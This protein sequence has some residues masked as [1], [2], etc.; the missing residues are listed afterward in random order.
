MDI[1]RILLFV[2]GVL[3]LVLI[4]IIIVSL[5]M[6][7]PEKYFNFAGPLLGFTSLILIPTA[8]WY[9]EDNDRSPALWGFLVFFAPVPMSLVLAFL[10][11]KDWGALNTNS[12]VEDTNILSEFQT[13]KEQENPYAD[14]VV[15]PSYSKS[16]KYLNELITIGSQEGFLS[17]EP[18]GNFNDDLHNKKARKIGEI[19]YKKG[20]KE[21]MQEVCSAVHV[22]LGPVKGKELEYAWKHDR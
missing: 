7:L 18:G 13:A 21:L 17:L 3:Y 5:E 22:T 2:L 15:T 6:N 19:L 16:D 20:G 9:A 4:S 11:P 12:K 1:K 10:K 14:N 8:Y